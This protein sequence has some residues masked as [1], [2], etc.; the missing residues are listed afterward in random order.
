MY[1]RGLHSLV[2]AHLT[3]TA[4]M[5]HNPMQLPPPTGDTT[6]G[7]RQN[8]NSKSLRKIL[9]ENV[10]TVLLSACKDSFARATKPIPSRLCL[11]ARPG[12]N[13]LLAVHYLN[14]TSIYTLP[15]AAVIKDVHWNNVAWPLLFFLHAVKDRTMPRCPEEHGQLWLQCSRT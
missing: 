8:Q 4:C 9:R 2:R 7:A 10:F 3:S 14:L 11:N 6:T 5:C 1:N 13:T 12:E 15:F